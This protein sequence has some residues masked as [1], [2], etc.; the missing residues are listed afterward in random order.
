MIHRFEPRIVA[1]KTMVNLN[2]NAL[3]LQQ[4]VLLTPIR[5]RSCI[6]IDSIVKDSN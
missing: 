4:F 2:S 3:H 6:L 5:R 1:V